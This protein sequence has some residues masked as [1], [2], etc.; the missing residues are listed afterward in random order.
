M[1]HQT[2][3]QAVKIAR[4]SSLMI[5]QSMQASTTRDLRIKRQHFQEINTSELLK[6]KGLF[7]T[8]LHISETKRGRFNQFASTQK[9]FVNAL[10][11]IKDF[12]KI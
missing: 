8:L 1:G 5:F 7:K 6:W 11:I 3:K 2:I 9:C 10:S 4:S 12:Q